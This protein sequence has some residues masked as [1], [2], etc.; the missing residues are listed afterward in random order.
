MA[1]FRFDPS[2]PNDPVKA[3]HNQIINENETY[4]R[5]MM[6]KLSVAYGD[7]WSSL[8]KK[9][10]LILEKT[11]ARGLDWY[12]GFRLQEDNE[13]DV[14]TFYKV[15]M[16]AATRL[17]AHFTPVQQVSD[18]LREQVF[19]ILDSKSSITLEKA[20]ETLGIS[21]DLFESIMS[22]HPKVRKNDEFDICFD[23]LICGMNDPER[24]A[25]LVGTTIDI[26]K[27]VVNS[28]DHILNHPPFKKKRSN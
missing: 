15:F 2:N 12:Q 23:L 17:N 20:A 26:A 19:N 4:F 27:E 5:D 10:I 16:D 28:F 6:N 25:V 7:E 3:L 13:I 24:M 9:K 18:E 21:L 11:L 14:E 22:E 8:S 1:L